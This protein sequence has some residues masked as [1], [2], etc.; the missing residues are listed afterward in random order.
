MREA[1]RILPQSFFLARFPQGLCTYTHFRI[2]LS[3]VIA[4]F[5]SYFFFIFWQFLIF[6]CANF[7]RDSHHW[8]VIIIHTHIPANIVTVDNIAIMYVYVRTY[9][10]MQ[11][12]FIYTREK[13]KKNLYLNLIH[14]EFNTQWIHYTN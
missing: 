1:H 8:T 14:N 2:I 5:A 11:Q 6:I 7:S 13:E 9:I 10:G 4:S 12:F 3:R